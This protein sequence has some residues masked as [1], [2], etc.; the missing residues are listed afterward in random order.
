NL[1]KQKW[2]PESYTKIPGGLSGKPTQ[3]DSNRLIKLA[4]ENYGEQLIII[5]I[6]GVFNAQ[7]AYTKIR[8]GASLVGLITGLIYEGPQIVG[9]I[10]CGVAKLLK[11]DGFNH[12]SEAIGFDTTV[13][14]LH[15][16]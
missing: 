3:S 15:N 2:D 11:Q 6:G 10:N 7:D 1:A 5:G 16:L 14:K 13:N 4:F 8:L 12:I 9:D